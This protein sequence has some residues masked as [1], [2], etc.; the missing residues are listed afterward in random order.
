[1]ETQGVRYFS[2]CSLGKGREGLIEFQVS[3]GPRLLRFPSNLDDSP[4]IFFCL[5]QEEGDEFQTILKKELKGA[6]TTK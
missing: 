5:H 4:C 3:Q 6:V 2:H 1:M